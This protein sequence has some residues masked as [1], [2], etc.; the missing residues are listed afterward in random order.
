VIR[1]KKDKEN[2][3]KRDRENRERT[4]IDTEKKKKRNREYNEQSGRCK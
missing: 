3:G 2:I 4:E 1:T